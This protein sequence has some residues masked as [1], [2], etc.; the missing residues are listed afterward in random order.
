MA[1][2]RVY[3]ECRVFL[4]QNKTSTKRE[5]LRVTKPDLK[6]LFGEK[7]LVNKHEFD[8]CSERE[9]FSH[10]CEDNLLQS[11]YK[12]PHRGWRLAADV[13]E[14][15]II[16]HKEK[17]NPNR[18]IG[19][20]ELAL[21]KNIEKETGL[22]FAVGIQERDNLEKCDR[23]TLEIIIDNA[24]LITIEIDGHTRTPQVS[25]RALVE[26]AVKLTGGVDVSVLSRWIPSRP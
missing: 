11:L 1:T 23:G 10:R 5:N 4:Q 7:R 6:S 18:R 8:E 20:A 21:K 2:K 19:R 22:G 17:N 13:P 15:D 25:V 9:K 26:N 12:R 3:D 14:L 24:I 16:H